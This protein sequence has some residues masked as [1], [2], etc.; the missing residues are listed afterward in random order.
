MCHGS[1]LILV[2]SQCAHSETAGYTQAFRIPSTHVETQTEFRA[3]GPT[4]AVAGV[5]GINY[6]MGYLCLFLCFSLSLK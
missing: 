2:S 1:S 3:R 5:W 4:L 6:K